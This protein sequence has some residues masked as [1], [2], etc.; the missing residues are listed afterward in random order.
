[1]CQP[2]CVPAAKPAT[3]ASSAKPG[4]A[5]DAARSRLVYLGAIIMGCAVK[6]ATSMLNRMS[7]VRASATDTIAASPSVWFAS[8]SLLLTF[9]AIAVVREARTPQPRPRM[10]LTP[11]E[12]AQLVLV[13]LVYT[14]MENLQFYVLEEV[15]APVFQTFGNL[16]VLAAALFSWLILGTRFKPHQYQAMLLLVVGSCLLRFSVMWV[17][18]LRLLATIGLILCSG[19]NLVLYEKLVCKPGLSVHVCNLAFYCASMLLHGSLATQT[20]AGLLGNLRSFNA[21]TVGAVVGHVFN[22]TANTMLVVYAGAVGKQFI[23]QGA[24]VAL[25]LVGIASKSDKFH[26]TPSFALGAALC[27]AGVWTWKYPP[28]LGAWRT[29]AARLAPKRKVR[30]D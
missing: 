16:K 30:V 4:A 10:R 20:E 7:R 18:T 1:M 26:L 28:N 2:V 23:S 9:Q 24:V 27:S 19:F 12:L 13:A 25:A 17:S 15:Q 11:A 29:V 3:P 6:S 5:A 14:V 22:G 8:Y 21:V